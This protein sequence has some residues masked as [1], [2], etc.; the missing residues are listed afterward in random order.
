MGAS[1]ASFPSERGKGKEGTDSQHRH[2]LTNACTPIAI[3]DHI[4]EHRSRIAGKMRT[5]HEAAR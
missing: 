1:G 2:S 5:N 3:P 4:P